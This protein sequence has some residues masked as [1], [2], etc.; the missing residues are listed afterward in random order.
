MKLIVQIPCLNE[1]DT[2]P[3]TVKDIPRQIEGIDQ[4]EIL[5]IDDGSTDRTSAVARE[6]GVDH[7]V[8]FPRN[9]GL[10]HAF[11]AG[12]DTCLKLGADIIVNTDG[13]NQYFGGDI[14]LLVKPILEGRADLVIGDR[15]TGA[16]GHFSPIKRFLQGAGSRVISRM[17]GIKV[18]D[19]ASGFRAYSRQAAISLSTFTNFDHT[20]EH[21]VKAGQDRLAVVC[22]PI[23][24]NPKA[25]ESRLFSNI[26][27]FV[28]KSGLISLRTYARY[29][30]LRIFALFGTLAFAGGVLLGL[31]F[32]YYFLFTDQ[33]FTHIQS[34]ILAAILLLAGFQM[35]LTGIVADLIATNRSMLEETLARVKKLELDQQDRQ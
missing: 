35:F 26:G 22:L 33:G 14:A 13:D 21:V 30:A 5:V 18:P 2:L 31:R 27:E 19:V 6:L 3:A 11:K 15:Q 17:A 29:Q 25:R 16:I 8:R 28:F 9:R 1:E 34:L 10:G 20:A 24:T 32:V 4:V 12:F 7:V 23:R